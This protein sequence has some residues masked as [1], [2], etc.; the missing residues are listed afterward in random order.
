M[1]ILLLLHILVSSLAYLLF[2]ITCCAASLY[3]YRSRRIKAKQVGLG[4]RFPWSLAELDMFLDHSLKAGL[5]LMGAGLMLGMA[6]HEQM[7]G[8]FGITSPRLIFPL[9]IWLFYLAA[10]LMR[11]KTGL[12]L[13]VQAHLM[14]WGLMCAALSFLYEMNL[15]TAI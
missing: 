2:G 10:L 12:G 5:A 1:S 8:S 3:L 4:D 14:A 11:R 9:C 7:Y 15:A 13:T 6:V